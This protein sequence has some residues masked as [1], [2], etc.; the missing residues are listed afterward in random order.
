QTRG[1][2]DRE[3]EAAVAVDAT[4]GREELF[5]ILY[6]LSA[7][8]QAET[9][10]R[11]LNRE[12]EERVD[13]RAAE[14]A[15]VNEELALE[16]ARFAAA[17]RQMPSGLLIAEVPSGRVLLA[18]AHALALFG[19]QVLDVRVGSESGPFG[20]VARHGRAYT[21]D[22]LPLARASRGETVIGELIDVVRDSR[23][24]VV[25]EVSAAPV[26]DPRGEIVA[27]VAAFNDVTAR[28]QRERIEREF[29]QN[30]AHQLRTPLAAITSAV[31]V[32]QAGAS[33]DPIARAKFL[34][35]IARESDRL[36][37]LTRSL[38]VLARAQTAQE[39]P[40]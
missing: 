9:E 28:E 18:N 30:A 29:I 4:G 3:I 40:E 16:Q 7:Q 24:P 36:A 19:D 1:E 26:R 23:P 13:M 31:A 34:D 21:A 22:E 35:H 17:F 32:L 27:A 8:V 15:R 5:W 38:L 14:L 37:R 10:L 20:G 11:L 2:G 6:D 25:L 12:L 39:K 33:D